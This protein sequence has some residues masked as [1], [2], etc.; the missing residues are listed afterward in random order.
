MALI[1]GGIEIDDMQPPVMAKLVKL[2]EHIG[3]NEFAAPSV[4]QLNDLTGLQIDTGDQQGM[5]TSMRWDDKNCLRAR[6]D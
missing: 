1:H 5:R 4:D 3:D 6:M 2:P